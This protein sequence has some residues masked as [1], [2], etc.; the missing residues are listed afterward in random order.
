[1]TKMSIFLPLSLF[2][3][4]EN[5]KNKNKWQMAMAMSPPPHIDIIN[6][7]G[8][9]NNSHYTQDCPKIITPTLII[10]NHVTQY[11]LGPNTALDHR[12]GI[13]P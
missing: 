13:R 12:H 2:R 4:G 8:E 10:T 9:G 1:M 5:R 11:T 7:R 3:H 6:K